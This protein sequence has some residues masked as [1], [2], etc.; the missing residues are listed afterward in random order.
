VEKSREWIEKNIAGA[1]VRGGDYPVKNSKYIAAAVLLGGISGVHKIDNMFERARKMQEA[2]ATG[3]TK[4]ET[5]KVEKTAQLMQFIDD[6]ETEEATAEELE[7]LL[8]DL[9]V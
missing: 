6:L 3:L 1:E 8:K 5:K 9:E 4:E 2:L 7:D